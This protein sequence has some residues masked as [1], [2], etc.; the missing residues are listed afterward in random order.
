MLAEAS[1][2]IP[3]ANRNEFLACYIGKS[4]LELITLLTDKAKKTYMTASAFAGVIASQYR[5]I[6]EETSAQ[7]TPQHLAQLRETSTRL[8]EALK[9]IGKRS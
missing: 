5:E 1:R 2:L 3:D 4:T 8:Y 9:E 6:T 7:H